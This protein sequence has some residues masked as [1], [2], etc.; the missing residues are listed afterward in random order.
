MSHDF[1]ERAVL[2]VMIASE[3]SRASPGSEAETLSMILEG[4]LSLVKR[5]IDIEVLLVELFIL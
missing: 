4:D 3:R 2:S 5:G 1:R